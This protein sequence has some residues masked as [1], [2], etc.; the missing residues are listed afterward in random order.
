[1][2]PNRGGEPCRSRTARPGCILA[3]RS[4]TRPVAWVEVECGEDVYVLA[5]EDAV[6][7]ADALLQAAWA[8]GRDLCPGPDP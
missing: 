7:L 6:H 5:P 1:M 8:C 3:V 2:T 4:K